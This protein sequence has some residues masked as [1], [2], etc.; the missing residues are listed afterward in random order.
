MDGKFFFFYYLNDIC[1]KIKKNIQDY[2]EYVNVFK[3]KK[4]NILN[5]SFQHLINVFLPTS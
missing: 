4:M 3:E 1:D 2:M 5:I